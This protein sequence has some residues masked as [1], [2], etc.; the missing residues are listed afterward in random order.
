MNVETQPVVKTDIA[1]DDPENPEKNGM[2]F[3]QG[4]TQ[5]AHDHFKK[6]LGDEALDTLIKT[7]AKYAIN[8]NVLVGLMDHESVGLNPDAKSS[9]GCLGLGQFCYATAKEMKAFSEGVETIT[10]KCLSNDIRRNPIQSIKAVGELLSRNGYY[11]NPVW[12]IM[13]YGDNNQNSFFGLIA[14]N[15]AR[16]QTGVF[17]GADKRWASSNYGRLQSKKPKPKPKKK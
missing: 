14:D 5:T 13:S 3:Q 17:S 11:A 6:K 15:V 2:A 7:A 1:E 9:T 12:A 8:P 16:F 10:V 4:L